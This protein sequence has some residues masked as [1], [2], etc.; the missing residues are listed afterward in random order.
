MTSSALVVPTLAAMPERLLLTALVLIAIVV[1][2]GLMRWGWV[3]RAGR[4]RDVAQL[5][6]VPALPPSTASLD[7]TDVAA[8]YLGANRSGDWFDRVV[9]HGLGTPS[10]ASV[11]VRTTGQPAGVWLVRRGAPDVYVAT[12]QVGGARHD[13]A[14][15]GRAVERD[16]LVVV[17]WLHGAS[18][19]ELGLRVR[20]PD[21]AEQLR[22]AVAALSTPS[23][24]GGR[25]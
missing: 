25:R 2:L 6:V 18:P 20:D 8:R 14:A 1:S 23:A 22:R 7:V 5:P 4:Q 10:E 15:A 16:A 12:G 9:A 21:R 11:S 13:R 3:R 19:L 17:E 24:A